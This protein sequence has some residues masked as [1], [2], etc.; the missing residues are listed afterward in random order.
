MGPSLTP[1]VRTFP[2][3]WDTW[4]EFKLHT[5]LFRHTSLLHGEIT[6]TFLWKHWFIMALMAIF[7]YKKNIR[8]LRRSTTNYV[9]LDFVKYTL[10]V[11]PM[12]VLKHEPVWWIKCYNVSVSYLKKHFAL[13][14]PLRKWVGLS[15]IEVVY[16]SQKLYNST[17]VTSCKSWQMSLSTNLVMFYHK[18][19]KLDYIDSSVVAKT[20]YFTELSSCISILFLKNGFR[21][22]TYL[23]QT[24]CS[25]SSYKGK[26]S[27]I[28]SWSYRPKIYREICVYKV[29]FP[30]IHGEC[31]N[32]WSASSE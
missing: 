11:R 15:G 26:W 12:C 5:F 29:C 32:S 21:F 19:C 2:E 6:L 31:L 16:L 23:C 13:N 25:I 20:K 1:E 17:P 9:I 14:Q 27:D 7:R 22:D 8:A 28:S 10:C 30:H 3:N 18:Y 4:N 24:R